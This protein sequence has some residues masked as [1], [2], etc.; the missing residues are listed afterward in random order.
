[1]SKAEEEELVQYIMHMS[2]RG[3]PIGRKEVK[4]LAKEM[5]GTH[6]TQIFDSNKGPSDGWLG[7]FIQ[8]HPEI[9]LRRPSFLDGGRFAMARQS[10]VN[11]YFDL[12]ETVFT[13][14]SLHD[15]PS[16]IYNLDETGFN[17]EPK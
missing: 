8:R 15:T 1:M 16:R 3:I 12:M 11:K 7:G 14:Y 17:R 13:E 6:A 10:T 4:V 5:D 9:S 2:G